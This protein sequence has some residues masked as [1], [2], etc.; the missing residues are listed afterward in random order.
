VDWQL[1]GDVGYKLKVIGFEKV[2][3]QPPRPATQFKRWSTW[4]KVELEYLMKIIDGPGG[5]DNAMAFN[6]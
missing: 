1:V 4:I 2:D 3:C 6:R 5:T